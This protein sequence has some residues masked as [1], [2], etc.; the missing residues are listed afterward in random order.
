MPKKDYSAVK[1]DVAEALGE[2]MNCL[3]IKGDNDGHVHYDFIH[4]R[5]ADGV[6]GITRILQEEGHQVIQQPGLKR[7]TPPSFF[8]KLKALKKYIALTKKVPI[9]WRYPR[10]DR[11][12]VPKNYS[13][14]ILSTEETQGLH[15]LAKKEGVSLNSYL[16]WAL[17][18]TILENLLTKDSDRKWVAPLNMRPIDSKNLIMGNY[19]AS[20]I[21]NVSATPTPKWFHQ[22]ISHYLKE[23]IHWGS[24]LYSNMARYI[25]FRGT[26]KVA[27][28][29]KEVGTGVFSNLGAW[30]NSG[31]VLNQEKDNIIWRSVLVPTTQILPVGATAWQWKEHLSL[32]LQLHPSIDGPTENCEL[33]LNEWIKNLGSEI[34]T[35]ATLHH[36]QDH[37]ECPHN[38]IHS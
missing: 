33:I 9:I 29:I 2:W 24:Q 11:T 18:K 6:S 36:W 19:S 25:G 8:N 21:S 14:I 23:G 34:T 37:P 12:G 32:S 22:Q 17:D 5:D 35:K 26:L 16:L 3:Y 7:G 38:L 4:H 28:G 30:P 27:K 31:I 13:M 20:I 15:H 10:I 1:F